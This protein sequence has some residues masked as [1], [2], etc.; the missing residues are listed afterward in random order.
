MINELNK[1][2]PLATLRFLRSSLYVCKFL[3]GL[4]IVLSQ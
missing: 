3:L 1:Y 2:H 4:I